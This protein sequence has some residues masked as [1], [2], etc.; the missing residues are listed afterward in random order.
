M[1]IFG[2]CGAD[3]TP[4]L[5]DVWVL[6]NA[7]GVNATPT[8]I[9]LSPVGPGPASRTRH[10][11]AYDQINNRMIVFAGQDGTANGC[12]TFSDVWV[13]SNANGLGGNP[14]WTQ[15]SP[16]GGPPTGQYAPTGIYDPSTNGFTVFGGGGMV[17]GVC[18]NS[19]ASWVLA[20]ANGLGGSPVWTNLTAEGASGSPLPRSFHTAVYNPSNSEMTIFGGNGDSGPLADVWGLSNANGQGGVPTWA[21]I[22]PTGGPP[23]ARNSQAAVL[24]SNTNQMTIFAGSGAGVYNDTWVLSL[25]TPNAQFVVSTCDQAHLQAAIT[26]AEVAGGTITFSCSG[27]ITLASTLTINAP[28]AGITIDGTGQNVTISGGGVNQVMFVGAPT[29]G[30]AR[31]RVT[32]ARP[33]AQA[34]LPGPVTL[35]NLTIT[36]GSAADGGAIDNEATLTVN[37]STFSGNSAIA[38]EGGSGGAIYND[39]MLTVNNSTFSGN[40]ATSDGFGGGSGGAIYNVGTLAVNG[41]TFTGDSVIEGLGGAIEN[42]EGIVTVTNSTFSGNTA[43]GEGSITGL[44]GAIEN[45][46]TLMVSGSTFSSNA[47][48]P[49]G[50]PDSFSGGGAIANDAGTATVT[51]STFTGNSAA[52]GGAIDN[53]QSGTLAVTF[54]TFWANS[55]STGGNLYNTV[56][57]S[58]SGPVDV[59]NSIVAGATSGGNCSGPITD[60]GFNLDDAA[61]CDFSIINGSFS[62]INPNLGPLANNGGPTQTL[63]LLP[64]SPAISQIPNGVNGCGTTYTTDQRGIP[65]PQP[66]GGFCSIGAYEYV[67]SLLVSPPSLTFTSVV[68][69]PAPPSQTLTAVFPGIVTATASVT[70]PPNVVWLAVAVGPPNTTTGTILTVTALPTGLTAGT[71]TGHVTVSASGD[72]TVP[73]QNIPVTYTLIPSFQVTSTCPGTVIIGSQYS[74]AG[75]VT[76]GTAP[77]VSTLLSGSLPPGM[78]LNSATGVISGTVG[79]SPGTYAFTIRVTDSGSGEFRQ[80][81]SYSCTITTMAP[82][83]ALQITSACPASPVAQNSSINQPLLATGGGGS[84][85][86]IIAGTLP[87]SLS[88]TGSTISGTVTA[89]PGTYNFGIN[90]SSGVQFAGISCS[91]VVT[92]PKLQIT[93]PCPG[94]GAQGAAYGP[95]NLGALGGLGPSSYQFSIV[96]GALP[97]GVGLS[98]NVIGGTPSGSG[99]FTFSIQVASGTQTAT[100][101]PCSVTITSTLTVTGTCP[102]EAQAGVP[103]SVPVSATGG[104]PPYSFSF[105][106][107]TGLSFSNGSV[108]G[109]ISAAGTGSFTVTVSDSAKSPPQKLSCSF[110]V[111][112]PLQVSGTCPAAPVPEEAPFSTSFTASGGTPP[113]AWSLSGPSWLSASHSTGSSISVTGTPPSTGSFPFSVTLKDSLG[114]STQSSSCT[115]VI[116]KPILRITP[117]ASC[118]ASPLPYQSMF[119][120]SLTASEGT[121][122]YAWAYSGPSWLTLST[123]SGVTTTLTGSATV[124]G[125]FPISVTLNDSAGSGQGMFSCSLTVSPPVIPPV[126]VTG[127][128]LNQDLTVPVAAGLELTA[129][130]LV[131]LTGTVTLTFTQNATNPI[132]DPADYQYPTFS[133]PCGR[134]CPFTIR[135]GQTTISLPGIQPG[136]VAGTIHV[137]VTALSYVGGSV[138][139]TTP[140]AQDLVVPQIAPVLTSG[141]FA[142]QT[143]TGYNILI[144][145]Y[146]TPRDMSS[147]AVTFTAAPGTTIQGPTQF[148]QDVTD[149]FMP[150][151]QTPA[152]STITGSSFKDLTIPVTLSGD[153]SAIATVTVTLTNSAGQSAPLTIMGTC[154]GS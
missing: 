49:D 102:M 53:G 62:N 48:N 72:S 97:A 103:I 137:E 1:I 29:S 91:L 33:D 57:D 54:T 126:N 31:H 82:P 135:S 52:F 76:G 153:S 37:N 152:R 70:S 75:L 132:T 68:G 149:L 66:P 110:P 141:C 143:S 113:Y 115:L 90:V 78:V 35:N 101:G 116:S 73:S 81:A 63:A 21:A 24:D 5:N 2:G 26:Q 45:E 123:K 32:K 74:F 84:Y 124:A 88:L 118:P 119:S 60:G 146:S 144:A 30:F 80:T 59:S 20:N 130:A 109:T 14:T 94:N 4:A 65:R 3:C 41:S 42:S 38:Y 129:P 87:A 106:G 136:L 50:I 107:S 122:P 43:T 39:G 96:G 10:A 89:S 7:N 47:A 44:G 120:L 64:R 128:V 92:P 46:G 8:W 145:G 18:Q 22:F 85:S 61:T 140:P 150:Y 77:Y 16:S 83:P 15:L 69:G 40:S 133:D 114:S 27:T 108:S 56:L 9:N 125:T 154:S 147:D 98:G 11:A 93:S 6:T 13:L 112:V 142:N 111:T 79:G 104:A 25:A 36:D 151:Y 58:S 55:A 17:G 131:T 139:P 12:S 95:F 148:T 19:N 34:S 138:L 117:S 23:P 51:S 99:T 86:W 105:S 67:P 28:A 121:A 71:Y 100:A 134:T 127:L